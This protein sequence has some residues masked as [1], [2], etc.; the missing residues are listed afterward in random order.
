M[1]R[2]RTFVRH[3]GDRNRNLSA[4]KPRQNVS[5]VQR[6]FKRVERLR[7]LLQARH[8]FGRKFGTERHDEIVITD[9][10]GSRGYLMPGKVEPLDTGMN[11]FH[12]LLK[13]LRQRAADVL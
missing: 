13:E 9:I 10:A 12:A 2:T 1:R 4:G 5:E 7:A 8:S 11:E 3:R 6:S